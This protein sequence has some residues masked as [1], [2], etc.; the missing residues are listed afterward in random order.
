MNGL[1]EAREIVKQKIGK[2]QQK[3]KPQNDKKTQKMK[4]NI[5]DRVMVYMQ[6]EDT[7]KQRKLALPYHSSYRI[8]ELKTNGVVMT[9]VD[10]RQE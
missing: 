3:Q 5:G 7:G 6:H 4:Y 1:T 10:K 8:L 2:S 9:P